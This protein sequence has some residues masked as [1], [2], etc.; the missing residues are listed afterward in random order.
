MPLTMHLTMPL[1][2]SLAVLVTVNLPRSLTRFPTLALIIL[3]AGW[4]GQS[5][6]NSQAMA[7]AVSEFL[8]ALPDEL[9]QRAKFPLASDEHLRW[10]FVPEEIFP[11]NGVPLREMDPEQQQ[12]A[13]TLLQTGLSQR[14]YMTASAIMELERVL[15]AIETNARF[16]RDNENYRVTVFGEPENEGTWAWRFEGHH[17][18]LH[19]QIVAGEVTVSTP[20]FFGSNPAHVTDGAQ[21]PEQENQRVLGDREDAGRALVTSLD[22]EQLE[23]A[24]LSGDAPRDIVTGANFPVDPL[25]PAGIGAGQLSN[26]Q[27]LL[28]RHLI[29][30]YSAA[31][32]DEIARK[33]WQKI[34]E[35]GFTTVSFAWAGSLEVG[36]PHY[37]RVQ[38][39]SFL[40]EYDN[41]QNGANHVHS[42]WRDFDGDFGEDLLRQHHA[43][44]QHE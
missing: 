35:D 7:E 34:E 36:E 44:F 3:L 30:V 26:S 2:K 40:I 11:R 39:P 32:T 27:Q 24:V 21:T 37:Y 23:I 25:Q 28:L 5:M 10:H 20:S 9:R 1:F 16:A 12:L 31:M 14:G 29:T 4:S 17:I 6:A 15:I 43:D 13:R 33:R 22:D 38:G 8:S 18:S 41:V 42:V 19:F